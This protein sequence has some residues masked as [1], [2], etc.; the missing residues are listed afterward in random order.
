MHQ[1]QGQK[2]NLESNEMKVARKIVVKTEID[3]IR[4]QYIRE[5]CGIELINE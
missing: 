2:Q 3:R 5:S 1:K 4:S